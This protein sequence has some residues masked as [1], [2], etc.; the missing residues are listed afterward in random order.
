MSVVV[1]PLTVHEAK[2]LGAETKER[3][4]AFL[5]VTVKVYPTPFVS[6][7]TVQVV[8]GGGEGAV[9]VEPDRKA[10]RGVEA[11][12]E[13]RSNGSRGGGR[14]FHLHGA[15]A[16]SGGSLELGFE[17]AGAGERMAGCSELLGGF[18]VGEEVGER[19]TG[20]V[21]CE[22]GGGGA[23]GGAG[24]G[25]DDTRLFAGRLPAEQRCLTGVGR[26]SSPALPRRRIADALVLTVTQ[27]HEPAGA[28]GGD[29]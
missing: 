27:P 13:E 16:G 19:E 2:A 28:I 21:C 24:D 25:S 11:S 1:W 18:A 6:P 22:S 15:E 26:L 7:V 12:V 29:P 5:A 10:E 4:S 3:G 14:E 17:G 8:A 9:G 20:A 23:D